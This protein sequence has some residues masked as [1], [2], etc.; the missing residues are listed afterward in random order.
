[1]MKIT[2]VNKIKGIVYPPGDKSISHRVALISALSD[3]E[4]TIENF[5]FADDT[6]KTLECLQ[7]LGVEVEIG[8]K[9]K[10]KG[11]GIKNFS[12]PHSI[13][14][15]GN[16]G[17]TIRLLA[18]ILAGQK[19]NSEITGDDSLRKRPMRRIV[20]PLQMMG[21]KI[22]PTEEGTAP[23]KIY[24]VDNLN[25][26]EYELEIPSA[27][28]KSCLIFAGL[29]ASG[30]TK[31]I[32]KIPTRDHTERLLGLKARF[33]NG[34]KVIEVEGGRKIEP[35]N[36][37]IPNDISSAAFFI[38]AGAIIPN[39]N[40]RIKNVTLNPTRTAFIEI[41]RQMG[42][43]I[44]TENVKEVMGEPIGDVIV[45]SK[46]EVN[47]KNLTLLG[48]VI[49]GIIDEIPILSIAGAIG[50]GKFE[51]RD[52]LELRKK[53]SDRIKAIVENLR[54]M[55]VD[56]EEYEDGFAFEGK[57]RLK[58][59]LIKTFNDH[60]IAMAFSIAGLI[61]EGETVI[62]NP[63][64]VKISFPSFFKILSSVVNF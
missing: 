12:S 58:G 62:D 36:Y 44:E 42:A 14:D 11:K 2:K 54:A 5:L 51:V 31:I 34:K 19:F 21:A 4:N 38:V 46:K 25:P 60:R 26:I 16:S 64:C 22:E 49:P 32:E 10:I 24:G 33:E 28:V 61:A 7:K 41:L 59:A 27:Q 56:V 55:G 52:A 17:T 45:K 15:A 13:L 39:S 3:G 30:K 37:L 47:L 18:G 6:N 43:D 23:L 35:A 1:M 40:I 29:H 48:D 20:K 53:E 63:D 8:G 50:E 9:L 57:N